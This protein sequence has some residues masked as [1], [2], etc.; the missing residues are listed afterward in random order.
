MM[1]IKTNTKKEADLVSDWLIY[2]GISHTVKGFLIETPNVEE[3]HKAEF[4]SAVEL[5]T[6]VSVRHLDWN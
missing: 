5:N 6:G 3:S 1:K 4:Y 2:C